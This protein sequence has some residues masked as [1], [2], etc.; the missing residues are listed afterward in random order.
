MIQWIFS[1]YFL[2]VCWF[3]LWNTTSFNPHLEKRVNPVSVCDILVDAGP[4]TNVCAPGGSVGLLGS[5]TGNELFYQWSP[6]TG[7]SN[8]FILNPVADIT[9][10]ITYTL[11][12]YGNDPSNPNLIV[13]GDFGLGNTGFDSD[14]TYVSDIPGSQMEMFPEGTYTVI[15]NPNL[16]HTGFSACNDHTGG[17]GNMMVVNGAASLQDIWCQTISVTPNTWY[18]VS[19]WVASVNPASPAKLRFSI[20]GTPIGAI[21]DAPSSTCQWIPFNAVWNS[22]TSITATIC[23]LNL[24]VATGGNDFAIDDISIVGLCTVEDEVE[25]T[26][27]QEVAPAPIIE[28]PAFLCEGEVG[29][30]TADFPAD[31]PILDYNWSVPPGAT[32]LDGQG[33][34]QVTVLWNDPGEESICLNIDTR[35]DMNEGCFEVTIGTVPELPLISG[36]N[37]LCPG[38]S[39]FLYTAEVDPDDQYQWTLPPEI[40]LVSGSGTNE[41]EIEW[42]NAGEV[43]ICLEVTNVCGTTDNCTFLTL[44]PGY[45]TLFDT[46]LCEGTTIIINGNTYGNGIWTGIEHFTSI[47]GC[48]S[49]VEIDISESTTLEFMFTEYLCPGDSV[50]LQG[51][52][53]TQEGIYIDSFTTV[54]NCDSLVITEVFLSP[55]DTTWISSNTCDPLQAGTTITTFNQGNCDSTVINQVFLI[56]AD[57]TTI[58][59]LSCFPSDTGQTIQLLSNQAG[60]DSLIITSTTLLSSDTTHFF[61]TTCNPMQVGTTIQNLINANGCDSTVISTVSFLESDTTVLSSLSCM[62]ADTGT[63][64]SLLINTMG[65][66]SLVIHHTLY[67]GS[68]TTFLFTNTCT[69]SDSGYILT[70]LSNQYGCDSIISAY[71]QLLHSD[72][73]YLFTTSC[74]PQDTGLTVQFFSNSA[75]CDSVVLTTTALE[76]IN[77]CTVQAEYSIQQPKCFGDTV[78]LTVDI[79]VGLGPFIMILQ[80][81]D[82]VFVHGYPST[83]VFSIPLDPII[84]DAVTIKLNSANGLSLLDTIYIN[85]PSPLYIE[86][87][88]AN[89]FN[90][91]GVPCYN[92]S[93]GQALVN[94]IYGGSPPLTYLWSNGE[95]LPLLSNLSSGIYQVTVSDNHGCESADSIEIT[96]PPPIEYQITLDEIKCFGQNNGAVVLTS[97]QGGAGPINTSLDGQS[98][99]QTFI[100]NGLSEGNHE[101]VIMDQNGCS[102][103]EPFFISEPAAWNLSVGPD[104]SIAFGTS[105]PL[106]ATIKGLPIGTLQLTWSDGQCENCLTRMIEA[107]TDIEYTVTGIDENGCISEDEIK[108]DVFIDR[109]LFIPNIFSPNGDQV[110]DQFIITSGTGL[111]EIEE[112]TIFD[113][114]GNLVFQEFHFQPNDQTLSWDG[115]MNGKSLNPGVYVY[116]MKV[117]FMDQRQE[118]RFGDITLVR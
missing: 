79:Q 29:I 90:G 40:I 4:D 45:L 67:G 19:A 5:I 54:S 56:P 81:E 74:E 33:T 16:V 88:L 72:T 23:I 2:L 9:G 68:D 49:L 11:T 66:D 69:P 8:A 44:Y 78:W 106:T 113:R 71:T 99:Q 75:G 65:C 26:L 76:S 89:D 97:V 53:Q 14:Y 114:W 64:S 105:F 110:N 86:A 101:V 43:E 39:A 30:Y 103:E 70:S 1:G 24:N 116:K 80:Y 58:S 63:T 93:L 82:I 98:F 57:T 104:T 108:L 22:G 117:V 83:G 20:N 92:D 21:I 10:P 95:N 28:G 115:T 87:Q 61:L 85:Y 109:D 55:F 17:G 32:L 60:C 6:V 62:Y 118:T 18:N 41:I 27:Y 34:T 59:I 46:I 102:F 48:D 84:I 36:P 51:A 77:L 94:I 91:F 37:S 7:L 38:E 73:T 47:D 13:N 100:Y 42:G 107:N 96:E 15:N 25:I 12:A 3:P 112:L 35:C 50:F 111:E 52:F 31:P